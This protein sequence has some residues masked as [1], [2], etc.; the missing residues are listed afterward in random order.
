MK[1]RTRMMITILVL[2]VLA[3][4]FFL[5]FTRARVKPALLL[6]T[7]DDLA[8]FSSVLAA[9]LTNES[10]HGFL[11]LEGFSQMVDQ[12]FANPL[13]GQI[14]DYEKK[15]LNLEIYVTDPQGVVQYDSTGKHVGA[16][17]SG[18]RDVAETLAGRYGAR[19]TWRDGPGSQRQLIF[20]VACPVKVDGQL[21]GVVSV[22][23]ILN[24]SY[25]ILQEM[26]KEAIIGALISV[27]LAMVWGLLFSVWITRPIRNLTKYV[28]AVRDG[29]GGQLP[30]LGRSDIGVLGQSFEEMRDALEGKKYVEQFVQTLT[31]EIKSPLSAI[32]GASELLIE[33]M[34]PERRERF[35]GNILTETKRIQDIVD[36]LLELSAIESRKMPRDP[37]EV[38]MA[39]LTADALS[40]LAPVVE[41]RH[42]KVRVV[43]DPAFVV[44]GE[45]FLLHLA[46][47]NLLQNAMEFSPQGGEV[48]VDM[49]GDTIRISDQGPGIPD[50]ALPRIFERFYSLS[51]PDT[52]KKSS[53]LG[54]SIV[55]SVAELH[56]GH[57][58]LENRPEGGAMATWEWYQR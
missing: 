5:H 35:L 46:I 33:D 42:L 12:A 52:G 53:G 39:Q 43:G 51:R 21:L 54:L 55:R 20:F 32:K 3:F 8:D 28:E 25:D 22:G 7:E 47:S 17:F 19:S 29:K 1:V 58:A 4:G 56:H 16:D 30:K 45:R 9:Q 44:R 6:P 24:F 27:G 15:E 50:Y 37:R 23:K 10:A 49:Q 2:G 13:R 31:H 41:K 36:R 34:P 57:V 40:A 11:A 18:W 48:V 14:Y 26:R 38:D